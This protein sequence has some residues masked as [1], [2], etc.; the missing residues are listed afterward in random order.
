M[1]SQRDAFKSLGV[2]LRNYRSSWS[3]KANDGTIAITLW[4]DLMDGD[5]SEVNFYDKDG[6][7]A[8]G[9]RG[10]I[11]NQWRKADVE[12]ALANSDGRF[13]AVIVRSKEETAR[14]RK[15]VERYV[16][17]AWWRITVYENV[18]GQLKARRLP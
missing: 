1:I 3:G 2:T 9:W 8:T 17:D 14:V 5:R 10:R 11:G 6:R 15:I 16:D 4:V 12:F 18:H 7:D 13:R